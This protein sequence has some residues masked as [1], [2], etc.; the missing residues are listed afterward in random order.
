VAMGGVGTGSFRQRTPAK[1]L[2]RCSLQ[3]RPWIAQARQSAKSCDRQAV[4]SCAHA[5]HTL[6]KIIYGVIVTSLL[7]VVLAQRKG[8]SC[9]NMEQESTREQGAKTTNCPPQAACP[10]QT[11]QCTASYTNTICQNRLASSTRGQ[12]C[13]QIVLFATNSNKWSHMLRHTHTKARVSPSCR[14]I[15]RRPLRGPATGVRTPTSPVWSGL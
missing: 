1:R 5:F 2:A 6:C 15:S 4:K 13:S 3:S 14:N 8:D 10:T 9:H 12:E 11:R 7:R